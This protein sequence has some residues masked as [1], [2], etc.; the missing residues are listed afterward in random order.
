MIRTRQERHNNVIRRQ[1][2]APPL[3]PSL[4]APDGAGFGATGGGAHI[5]H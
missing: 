5:E 4:Y 2:L 1:R 3:M